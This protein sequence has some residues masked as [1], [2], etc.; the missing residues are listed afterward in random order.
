MPGQEK[1]EESTCYGQKPKPPQEK[2]CISQNISG[3]V[4]LIIDVKIADKEMQEDGKEE[5]EAGVVSTGVDQTNDA[6]VTKELRT[7]TERDVLVERKNGVSPISDTREHEADPE[8]ALPLT[9]ASNLPPKKGKNYFSVLSTIVY[10]CLS[11]CLSVCLTSLILPFSISFLL[12]DIKQR[13]K[14]T[15]ERKKHFLSGNGN[16]YVNSY[17]SQQFQPQNIE[18]F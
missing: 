17:P 4:Q 10:L 7:E 16:P 15:K 6:R 3:K 14:Q 8:I 13:R 11:V 2:G 12:C 1:L 9:K 5:R 18:T